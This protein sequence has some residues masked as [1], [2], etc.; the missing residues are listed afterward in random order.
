MF[1]LAVIKMIQYK[2]QINIMKRSEILLMVLQ[3]P[4]DLLLLL[5]AAISAYSLRFLPA[6]TSWRPV[7]F[8]ISQQEFISISFIFSILIILIFAFNGLYKVNQNKKL[9]EDFKKIVISST[10]GL[11][12]V[13]TYM[14]F[15]QATF[16]SRFLIL[17]SYLFTIIFVSLG[18]LFVRTVK[19]ILYRAGIGLRRIVVIGE[20]SIAQSII[21]S[22]NNRK[23]LGYIVVA[24]FPNFSTRVPAQLDRL[25]IDEIIFTDPRSREKEALRA[26]NYATQN[27][28]V[29][30]YSA[31]LF[32]TYS[33]LSSIQPLA[34]IPIVELK[35][36]KLGAWGRV[37][38]R[39]FD[40]FFSLLVI[41]IL[42]PVYILLS[43]LILL[44]TGR[45]VIYK[46]ERV[47][48][49][50][51]KFWLYKFRSM[52]QKD[53]TG[54]QFGNS[55]EKALKKELE[56]IKKNNSKSGPIYKINNDPRVTTLGK[57]LRRASLDELPQ[58]VNVLKGEMSIVGPR[59]HQP[60][61][62][63]QYEK[64]Y[65]QIFNLKPGI[66]GL[67]QISGR[68]DLSFE[69]EM[70]LDIFYTEKWS[71]MLDIIICIK[72]PFIILKKR[73]AL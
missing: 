59:P 41:I 3:V 13:A 70:K 67:A 54:E 65:K 62:V 32:A 56:L 15:F 49:R 44:E 43:F 8:K 60:R 16:D 27:H 21:D 4:V 52:F 10:V 42:S 2:Q 45:P 24:N 39:L 20:D 66:T 69:D 30:K 34:G 6:V 7:L 48:I 53:S 1:C 5:L 63:A 57:I 46:N 73:K 26:I 37:A 12:L 50:G 9:A 38:K 28:K 31:D 25:D 40:V 35:K 61:E 22:L 18:H 23:E 68:S 55:G 72:T 71:L 64:E 36:T 51:K 58:F 11:G 29:F 14:L 17:F 33:N 47:G 19:A